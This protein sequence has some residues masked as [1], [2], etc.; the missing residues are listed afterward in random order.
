VI[1]TGGT[2][3]SVGANRLDLAWY[4]EFGKPLGDGELVAS[5]PELARIAAV[6]EF[7][8]R[9]VPSHAL[10]DRDWLALVRMIHG[11]F[12]AGATWS[13]RPTS[14]SWWWARCARRRRSAPTDT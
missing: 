13:S 7:P 2:I 6:K 14:P 12:D 11:I 9:R 3:D 5:V 8:F 1:L 4:N 10:V